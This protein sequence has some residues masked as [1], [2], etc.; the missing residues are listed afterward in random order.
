[1]DAL[2]I[3]SG[4]AF[5]SFMVGV[6]LYKKQNALQARNKEQQSS[7][8]ENDLKDAYQIYSNWC[9]N[10]G[11]TP[12]AKDEF[13]NLTN[14]EGKIDLFDLMS[15]HEN[16]K[17]EEEIAQKSKADFENYKIKKEKEAKEQQK[18]SNSFAISAVLGYLT[19]STLKGTLLGG[20]LLGAMTGSFLKKKKK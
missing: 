16:V 7:N 15:F 2:L 14:A 1:M 19:D 10:N 17:I 12:I 3:L 8:R 5:F 20:N 11:E 18:E 9:K 13:G 4:I 6:F